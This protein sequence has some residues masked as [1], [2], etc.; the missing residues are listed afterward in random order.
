M[1]KTFLFGLM[2]LI[3]FLVSC[4]KENTSEPENVPQPNE[5]AYSV[6]YE[7]ALETLQSTLAEIDTPE[8]RGMVKVRTIANHYTVGQ[9]IGSTVTRSADGEN[10]DPYVHI[11]NFEDE[12]GYAIISG[13][14]RTAPVFAITESGSLEEGAEVDNPGLIVFLANAEALYFASIENYEETPATRATWAEY[15]SW[16]NYVYPT[17]GLAF[18]DWN[19]SYSPYND[20]IP[21]VNGVKIPHAGCVASAAAI[22]MAFHKYPSYYNGY[23]YN[24]NEMVKHRPSGSGSTYP[25]AYTQIARLYEQLGL[26]KNLDMSYAVDGSSASFS[27]IVRTLK[28]FGYSN[29]GTCEGYNESKVFSELKAG[30]AVLASAYAKK[31]VTKKKFLGITVKTITTYSRGHAWVLDRIMSRSRTITNYNNG[32]V[33]SRTTET[34]YLVHCNWG[35]GSTDNGYYFSGVWNADIGD[36]TTRSEDTSYNFQYYL[37]DITG[38]RK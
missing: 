11:F 14:K 17:K 33:S 37:E 35:W 22:L 7:E 20:L 6:S 26:T 21:K 34:Q 30:Y 2:A 12:E 1:K 4:A 28:N 15:S 38:I 31:T 24:W 8:T 27:N 32:V 18:N 13:D 9:P 10:P 25:A 3:V 19:Q 16:T 29:G 23:S 5:P 36:V